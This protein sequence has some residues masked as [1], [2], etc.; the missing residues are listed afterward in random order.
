MRRL[1]FLC[2]LLISLIATTGLLSAAQRAAATDATSAVPGQYLVQFT[3]GTSEAERAALIEAEGGRIVEQLTAI[4]VALIE[5]PQ[6]ESTTDA[7]IATDLVASLSQETDIR[8]IEP[9][10]TYNSLSESYTPNDP[11]LSQQYAWGLI[12]AYEGWAVTRGSA[13]VVI[14]IID[15]GVQLSHP[16]LSARLLSGYDFVDHDS[17]PDD[18]IGHGTHVAG[19]AA[20]ST[21]NSLGGAGTCP[22]CGLLP[23]RVMN[24]RGTGTLAD[25]ASGIIYA[26]D[27]GARVINLSL[28]GGGSDTLEAAVNYA[29]SQG[30]F[31]ACAAGND[32]T[33]LTVNAYPAAYSACFAVAAS[34]S[35]DR[36]AYYSNYGAW[37][38]VAAPGDSIMSS[39]TN[40]RYASL[41]GTS[42]ATPH[43]A[44]LAG[45][46][47]AQGLSNS[48]IRDRICATADPIEGT[49]TSWT[50]GRINLARAVQAGNTAELSPRAYLPAISR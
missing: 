5:F 30:V 27:S 45:L 38:E 42:M 40:S 33:N 26:A 32:G 36:A 8:Y 28:G 24:A 39:Y 25:I 46:L 15:S 11:L 41:S 31:L 17:A 6:L 16:D 9:N 4:D 34:T 1:L 47:A 20:A 43:V 3:P 2:S 10:T 13:D 23:V 18:P 19:I 35:A 44:G 48:Q 14:A 22:E 37:V 49:G 7:Q 50:C 12:G 21:N 29:W